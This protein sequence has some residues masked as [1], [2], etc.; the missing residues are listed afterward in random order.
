MRLLLQFIVRRTHGLSV[1]IICNILSSSLQKM[2]L[3]STFCV[4]MVTASLLL[5]IFFLIFFIAFSFRLTH[6]WLSIAPS[7]TQ[8]VCNPYVSSSRSSLNFFI[9]WGSLKISVFLWHLSISHVLFSSSSQRDSGYT[10][11]STAGRGSH[12]A[13][14]HFGAR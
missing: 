13:L 5:C 4:M 3:W 10:R 6:P 9:V 1:F 8:Y 14:W 7:H 12:L 2:K 11:S